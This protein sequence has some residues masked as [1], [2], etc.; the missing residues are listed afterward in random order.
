L[1]TLQTQHQIRF[2]PFLYLPEGTGDKLR[3]VFFQQ[4]IAIPMEL[5]VFRRKNH[6]ALEVP[7]RVF[8]NHYQV[9]DGDL[10]D[11]E[12]GRKKVLDAYRAALGAANMTARPRMPYRPSSDFLVI[13]SRPCYTLAALQVFAEQS[14]ARTFFTAAVAFIKAANA[15]FSLIRKLRHNHTPF[16][17]HEKRVEKFGRM[18]RGPAWSFEEDAILRRWFGRRT[19]GVGEAKHQTLTEQEWVYVL[20]ALSGQRTKQSVRDRICALNKLLNDEMS[21][22]G[23]VARSRLDEYMNRVLGERPRKPKMYSTKPTRPRRRH[24]VPASPNVDTTSAESDQASSDQASSANNDA[25]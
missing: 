18:V 13:D 14:N 15:D 19:V 8:S 24:D 10:I 7:Y 6:W 3:Q 25:P 1:K 11:H 17:P 12:E 4:N 21:V 16:T 22:D 5:H 23:Y 2:N 20:E 9:G